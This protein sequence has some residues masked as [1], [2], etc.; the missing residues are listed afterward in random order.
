MD[1]K[2]VFIKTQYVVFDVS[3]KTKYRIEQKRGF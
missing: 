2:I 1:L 3:R